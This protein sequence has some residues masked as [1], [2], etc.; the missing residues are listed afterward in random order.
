MGNHG[1]ILS[2]RTQGTQGGAGRC[3]KRP[4][5]AG[6]A[7]RL[8]RDLLVG[9]GG[10]GSAEGLACDGLVRANRAVEADRGDKLVLE[11][12]IGTSRASRSRKV[13][14][15]VSVA[16]GV[17]S[18][19]GELV[20]GGLVASCTTGHAG[21]LGSLWLIGAGGTRD[22]CEHVVVGLKL[23]CGAG[24]ACRLAVEDLGGAL[25]TK[26]A[27]GLGVLILVGSW[28]ACCA[29]GLAGGI[30][31]RALRTGNT[32]RLRGGVLIRADRT[33]YTV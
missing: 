22:A 30:L 27:C 21:A 4:D 15:V 13:R 33:D 9:A 19:L 29:G 12:P 31:V 10:A 3:L 18:R 14:G 23:T 7:G 6:D 32:C 26:Q 8:P 17:T 11:L 1:L 16:A 5:N 28:E 24:L 25:R 20:L 2:P